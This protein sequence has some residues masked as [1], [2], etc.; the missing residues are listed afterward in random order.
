MGVIGSNSDTGCSTCG[1]NGGTN[2]GTEFAQNNM[3]RVIDLILF[4]ND[5]P[6]ASIDVAALFN[7]EAY[8]IT[9]I[10]TPVI[11]T[12]TALSNSTIPLKHLYL[13]KGGKG[14][15][16]SGQT[17]VLNSQFEYITSHNVKPS[18]ID[19]GGNTQTIALGEL[20]DSNY[21]TAANGAERDLSDDGIIYFFSYINDGVLYLVQFIGGYGYYGGSYEN[22]FTQADFVDT[23]NDSLP[24]VPSIHKP[25]KII[26][27]TSAGFTAGIYTIQ[28]SDKDCWLCFDLDSPFNVKVPTFATNT[29]IEGETIGI[30]Q[31]TFSGVQGVTLT[32]PAS[33][34][35]TTAERY[36]VFGLKFRTST[37]VSLY[38]RLALL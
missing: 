13:F 16:G 17:S 20:L 3:G 19:N 10:E 5:S 14:K 27:S 22:T 35:P 24:L 18:D 32:Y 33:E 8:T 34:S 6:V 37:T 29:L 23:T 2:P 7:R 30:G 36:S 28:T 12:L 9:D 11:I 21:L 26:T 31:A 4:N 1:D 15:W 25:I 38:G